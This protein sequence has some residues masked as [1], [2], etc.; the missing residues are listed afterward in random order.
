[1]PPPSKSTPAPPPFPPA[2]ISPCKPKSIHLGAAYARERDQIEAHSKQSGISLGLNLKAPEVRQVEKRIEGI[3]NAR[4]QDG[5]LKK[6][7]AWDSG[8]IAANTEQF[9]PAIG[10]SATHSRSQS[11]EQQDYLRAIGSSAQAGGTVRMQAGAGDFEHYRQPCVWYKAWLAAAHDINI[12]A[13]EEQIDSSA[14]SSSKTNGL[15]G[16]GSAFSR[17][18]GYRADTSQETGSRIIHSS[19]T[20]GSGSGDSLIRA[21]RAYRQT[22]SDGVDGNIDIAAQSIDIAA[23]PNPYQSGLPQPLHPKRHHQA[24]ARR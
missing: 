22:G 11:Q 13:A 21:G 16:G 8:S 23:A 20:A 4:R 6:W 12:V 3:Q 24:C 15:M 9:M 19:S 1:M 17:F 18:I 14:Q 7:Q 10:F 5:A 2:T